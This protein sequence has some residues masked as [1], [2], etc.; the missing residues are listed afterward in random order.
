MIFRDTFGEQ[1]ITDLRV[2]VGVTEHGFHHPAQH[3]HVV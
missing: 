2:V 3:G 1:P